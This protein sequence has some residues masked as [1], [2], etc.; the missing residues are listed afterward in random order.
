MGLLQLLKWL[1]GWRSLA[2]S[3]LAGL[4]PFYERAAWR[5]ENSSEDFFHRFLVA[6]GLIFG[7]RPPSI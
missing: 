3:L 4:L 2:G 1:S 7:W 6:L 5:A